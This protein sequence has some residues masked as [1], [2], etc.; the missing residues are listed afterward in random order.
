[1]EGGCRNAE[2]RKSFSRNSGAGSHHGS[3]GRKSSER[4]ADGAPRME[5]FYP[6]DTSRLPKVC[7]GTE[8]NVRVMVR[9]GRW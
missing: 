3:L 2:N 5:F 1:M 7:V 9:K 4:Y 8:L 6:P